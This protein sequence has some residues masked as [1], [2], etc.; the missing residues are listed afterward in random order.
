MKKIVFKPIIFVLLFSVVLIYAQE[1]PKQKNTYVF[2]DISGSM[3]P[4][5]PQVRDYVKDTV[6]PA[7]P[8]N[9]ELHIF[10][11]YK[12]LVPIFSQTVRSNADKEYAAER[13][14]SLLSHGAWT[15]IDNIFAYLNEH[16]LNNENAIIYICTDGYEQLENYSKEYRLTADTITQYTPD[17]ELEDKNG[18]FMLT[19]KQP[20]TAVVMPLEPEY[21]RTYCV[22][23]SD[24]FSYTIY[25]FYRIIIDKLFFV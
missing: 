25:N 1:Q 19:W 14:G 7:V 20:E 2:I 11:F 8:L 22:T 9:S 16:R 3:T 4:I 10:K 5:F 15:D 17:M 12:K 23:D 24:Y 6:I 18:W 21:N 13:V